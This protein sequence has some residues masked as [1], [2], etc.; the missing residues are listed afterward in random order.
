MPEVPR[1]VCI[2]EGSAVNTRSVAPALDRERAV[3]M[4]YTRD[5]MYCNSHIMFLYR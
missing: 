5:R 4:H 3:R 1:R 2:A